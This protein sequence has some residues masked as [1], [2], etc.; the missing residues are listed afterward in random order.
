[1]TQVTKL[2]ACRSYRFSLLSSAECCYAS[3]HLQRYL[4]A[5]PLAQTLFPGTDDPG[6]LNIA[7]RGYAEN[8]ANCSIR[9]MLLPLHGITPA[10]WL[11]KV[12]LFE[13]IRGAVGSDQMREA[14]Y[15]NASQQLERGAEISTPWPCGARKTLKAV[16][17][18]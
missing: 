15:A 14:A 2:T 16:L 8:A 12:V 13:E 10:T 4:M 17:S 11:R 18:C 9:W 5:A 7:F 1:M 3:A 6:L